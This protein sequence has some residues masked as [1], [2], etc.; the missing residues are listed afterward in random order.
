LVFGRRDF[1]TG[2]VS[3]LVGISSTCRKGNPRMT[4]H[5][6]SAK[7]HDRTVWEVAM[8]PDD[9]NPGNPFCSRW[10]VGPKP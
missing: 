1:V 7:H 5:S 9:G 6:A 3:G 2:A 8:D 4:N 10:D